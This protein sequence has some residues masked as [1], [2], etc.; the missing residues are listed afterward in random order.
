MFV[1]IKLTKAGDSMLAIAFVIMLFNVNKEFREAFLTFVTI[2]ASTILVIIH[3]L[4]FK[5]KKYSNIEMLKMS[6][7]FAIIYCLIAAISSVY[8]YTTLSE[9]PLKKVWSFWD[10]FSLIVAIFNI[11]N[12]GWAYL[13]TK[14][15]RKIPNKDY[16]ID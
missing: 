10:V 7:V 12:I 4:E 13:G 6:T 1:N 16:D 2:T 3:N 14:L 8:L 5:S 11:I 15:L 9:V